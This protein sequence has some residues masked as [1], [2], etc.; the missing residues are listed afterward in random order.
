MAGIQNKVFFG[1]GDKITPTSAESIVLLQENSTDVARINYTGDPEGAISANP[2]SLCHDPVSGIVYKKDSGVS[3]TG[4][5][6]LG[7][8]PVAGSV[9]VQSFINAAQPNV[10]G[11][12]T[13]LTVVWS[14]NAWEV[15]GSNMNNSTGVF[16]PPSSGKYLVMYAL[17]LYGLTALNTTAE[18]KIQINN[19]GTVTRK[20]FNPGVAADANGYYQFNDSIVVDIITAG[21]VLW[22]EGA[23]GGG[24]GATVSFGGLYFGQYS[25]ISIFKL[26][27]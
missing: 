20:L 27:D 9:A 4:W 13:S 14:G 2:A 22:V 16:T 15:G 3:N 1:E 21:N 5:S 12:G 7:G 26:S 19:Q 24:A 23:V 25:Y 10:T 8:A 6:T 18:F 11:D 17:T